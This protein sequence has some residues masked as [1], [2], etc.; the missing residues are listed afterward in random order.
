M[1]IDV[2][3]IELNKNPMFH[4]S[5]G[6]KELFHSN[7]WAFLW[8]QNPKA[9]LELLNDLCLNSINVADLLNEK[10]LTL[11]R[12]KE[13]FDICIHH[14]E[15]K[16]EIYDIIIENKVKSIPYKEQ[17]EDYEDKVRK[18]QKGRTI[19][20]I[21]LTL[22]DNFPNANNI[23]GWIIVSY[24]ALA[25]KL[26]SS[27]SDFSSSNRQILQYI[28]DYIDFIKQLTPL[29]DKI[30]EDL[31]NNGPYHQQEDINTFHKYKLSDLYI[32]LRG[33]YFIGLIKDKLE[34]TYKKNGVDVEYFTSSKFEERRRGG[35]GEKTMIWLHSG[36][37]RG[38]STVTASINP[39]NSENL[40]ELQI[41]G[42]QY[43]HMFNQNGLVAKRGSVSKNLLNIPYFDY[44]NLPS[45]VN[46]NWAGKSDFNQYKP[47]YLYKYVKFDSEIKVNEMIDILVEDIQ[48]VL[49]YRDKCENVVSDFLN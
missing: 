28:E 1:G 20:N 44:N 45:K 35:S 8:D 40:Y 11:D 26:K 21:L 16:K 13:N 24:K 25:Q 7:F 46:N 34:S 31:K 43:R 22:A 27:K 6:S 42:D 37:N 14:K 19:K 29:K 23:K 32:K 33:A 47:N 36:M 5:L 3:L 39:A 38:K 41:E 49:R 30:L 48:N 18:H 15:G 10:E 12:E 2:L 17:L 9:F 4:L